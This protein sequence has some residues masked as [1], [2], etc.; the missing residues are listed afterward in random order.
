MGEAVTVF[1]KE[2]REL[3]FSR[4]AVA[5]GVLFAVV[6]GSMYSLRITGDMAS[7]LDVSLG[8]LLFFLTTLLGVFLGYSF[9]S[10]VFLREKTDGVI[11]TL[12]CSP[13]SLRG[14]WLGKTLAVTVFSHALA[15]VSGVLTALVTSARL[16]TV[17]APNAA[18]LAYLVCVVPL[19]IACLVGTLGFAQLLLGMKE[20]RIIGLALFIPIFAGLYGLGYSST[21][22]FVVAW[23]HVGLVALGAA[24]VLA[25]IAW[26]SRFLN[27]E[28]IVTTLP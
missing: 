19:V 8:S 12:L 9:T 18:V 16:G 3:A 28:R 27:R 23:L 26:G 20:N 7:T 1:R 17:A 2:F 15:V 5:S 22:T 11:E 6:F 14:L 21:G 10:Q 25:A 4:S 24:I 13:A